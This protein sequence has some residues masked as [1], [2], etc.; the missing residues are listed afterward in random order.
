MSARVA[1][2]LACVL[3]TSRAV[4]TPPLEAELERGHVQLSAQALFGVATAPFEVSSLRQAKGQAFVFDAAARYAVTDPLSVE[5]RVP[6]ILGS[7]AQPAGS[8]VDAAALGNPQLGARYR[9]ASSSTGA[10]RFSVD[11][12]LNL[13]LPVASHAADLM[14]NRLLAIANGVEGRGRPD[15]FSPGALPITAGVRARWAWPAWSVAGALELPLLIRTSQADLPAETTHTKA[16]GFAIIAFAEL[17]YRL[18]RRW[19][20]AL[21]EQVFF[22]VSPLASYA[23]EVSPIQDFER[24]GVHIQLGSSTTLS[25]DLQTAIAGEL[26]GSM[27]AGGLRTTTAF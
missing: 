15:W 21:A 22:D 18:T 24:L 7:V 1:L 2:L 19:T 8:Y 14:P 3:V 4:A 10:A 12:L 16:L 17:R 20:L 5:L 26:G 11:A 23:A 27:L 13:G 6:W 9:I 25:I